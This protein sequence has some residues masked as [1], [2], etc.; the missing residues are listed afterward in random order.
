M[1]VIGVSYKFDTQSH[2]PT[3]KTITTTT[4]TTTT[5]AAAAA[6]SCRRS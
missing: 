4:T 5:T 3:I 1:A 6:A 2:Y